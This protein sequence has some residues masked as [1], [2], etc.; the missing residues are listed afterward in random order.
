MVFSYFLLTNCVILDIIPR[1][2]LKKALSP[3]LSK[4]H[5]YENCDLRERVFGFADDSL[6]LFVPTS[7]IGFVRRFNVVSQTEV[8]LSGISKDIS[9]HLRVV[10][11]FKKDVVAVHRAD[12]P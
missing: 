10:F 2:L 4:F 8:Q 5:G 7:A 3:A 1:R 11:N 12:I 6:S 9:G